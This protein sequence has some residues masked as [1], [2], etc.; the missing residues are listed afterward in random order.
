LEA[1][2]TFFINKNDFQQ[3]CR[4]YP[5]VAL[6]VLAV[7]G[8]RLRHLVG[9]VESMTFGSVTQHLARLL[10]EA[11]GPAGAGAFE[12]PMTHQE[13]ASRL[14]TEREVVSRNLARFRGDGLIRIQDRQVAILNRTG[15]EQEAETES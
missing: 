6:K 9:P 8:R 5:D 10:L 2:T 1:T 11:A 15:L 13:L 7:V 12:L 14:G 4:Q 3:V